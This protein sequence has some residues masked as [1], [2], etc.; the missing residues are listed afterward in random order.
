MTS[1]ETIVELM[2]VSTHYAPADISKAIGL[3][4]DRSWRIGDRKGKSAMTQKA[5]GWVL[6]AGDSRSIPLD[7]QIA[8]LLERLR[9]V[10]R[11]VREM[12]TQARVVFA[13]VIY[14]QERPTLAFSNAV[15]SEI[16][17][18][19]ASFEIDLYWVADNQSGD[20]GDS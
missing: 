1:D 20:T 18:L 14:T 12:S 15:I 13:C 8:S 2:I 11:R 6:A 9:P 17:A 7:F 10:S 16:A 5:N 4:P 19:G 3:E